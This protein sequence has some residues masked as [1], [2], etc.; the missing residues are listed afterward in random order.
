[1]LVDNC[2]HVIDAAA[3][4]IGRLL[5]AWSDVRVLATSRSPLGLP[6]ESVVVLAPLAVPASGALD[7]RSGAVRLFCESARDNGV[8]ID[9]R[10]IDAVVELCR[11]LDGMPLAIELAAARV[12]V[13]GVVDL[14]ERVGQGVD[15]LARQRHRGDARHRS[16]HD[17]I[18]WSSQLLDDSDRDAFGRLAVCAGPFELE[19]AAAVIGCSATDATDVLERLVDASLVDVDRERPGVRYRMLEP[20]RAVAL[21]QVDDAGLLDETRERLAAHV[22]DAVVAMMTESLTCWDADLLPT[23]IGRFDQIDVAMRHCLDHDDE[24]TRTL[25]LYGAL[26]GVVHQARVDEVLASGPAVLERWPDP[27]APHGADAAATYAMGLLLDGRVDA[28]RQVAA[29]ALP[30]T[31]ASVLAAP[32]LRRVLALAARADGDHGRAEVLLDEAAV[33]AAAAWHRHRGPRV[34]DLPGAGPRRARKN[35]RGAGDRASGG[36]AGA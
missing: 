16:V 21:A 28:A 10:E 32:N 7:V 1:M 20:I 27:A 15:L 22:Y 8:E 6:G 2:E 4:V 31:D 23:L 13:L 11:R 12:R 19:T 34:P 9:D 35:R 17:T 14:A 26:W 36:G 25:L 29:G 18:V 33:A 30:H 24:P 5:E 3:D